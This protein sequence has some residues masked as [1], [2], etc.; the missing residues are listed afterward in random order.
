MA[1]PVTAITTN[2]P[3]TENRRISRA[4]EAG[5]ENSR[6]TKNGHH[7]LHI[8]A[9]S[10]VRLALRTGGLTGLK[11]RPTNNPHRQEPSHH[12]IHPRTNSDLAT[13]RVYPRVVGHPPAHGHRHH[14]AHASRVSI[15]R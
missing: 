6:C 4:S 14:G 2:I 3:R 5:R 11:R 10:I 9:R 8:G 13:R 1:R 12:A 15:V 7:D